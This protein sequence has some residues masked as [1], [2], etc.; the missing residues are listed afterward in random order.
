MNNV[1]PLCVVPPVMKELGVGSLVCMK[2]CKEL[3]LQNI[4]G[5][6]TKKKVGRPLSLDS[7]ETVV[8]IRKR[9]I[10]TALSLLNIHV[11]MELNTGQIGWTLATCGLC[12][13]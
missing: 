10:T 5:D 2:N 3:D 12:R 9:G 4:Y 6:L 7:T 1:L 11:R 8:T 13:N